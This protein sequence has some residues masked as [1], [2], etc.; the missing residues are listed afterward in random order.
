L[1]E[2]RYEL[3]DVDKIAVSWK[4]ADCI[5]V[6]VRKHGKIQE[7]EKPTTHGWIKTYHVFLMV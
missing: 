2:A 4:V 3:I 5:H 6:Q 7:G 1:S